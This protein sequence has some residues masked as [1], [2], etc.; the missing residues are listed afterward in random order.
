MRIAASNR[1]VNR[2]Q[3]IS[4]IALIGVGALAVSGC[5]YINPQSTGQIYSASDGVRTDL[6]KLELRNILVVSSGKD[7]PGRI[8]GAVF[9]TSDTGITLTISGSGGS[10]T[11][12]SVKANEPYYLNETT[13]ASILSSVSA[14]PGATETLTLSQD[15]SAEP[16]TAELTVPVLDGTLKEYQQ[17]IPRASPTPSPADTSSPTP[18]S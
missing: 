5:S 3:R 15:G 2:A 16:K 8:I 14:M 11:R 12:I 13:D 6:G 9:N 10:Q 17:Y 1:V 4:L 7:K 18:S